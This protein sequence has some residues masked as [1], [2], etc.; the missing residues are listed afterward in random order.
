MVLICHIVGL[1]NLIKQDFITF[2]DELNNKCSG[3]IIVRDLDEISQSIHKPDIDKFIWKSE[4]ER[5]VNNIRKLYTN[6]KLIFIGLCTYYRDLR[7]RTTVCTNNKFFVNLD[8]KENAKQ[9]VK[10]NITKYLVQIINGN[11]PLQYLDHNFI[12]NQREKL[13]SLYVNMG[14]KLKTHE[15][16]K[17]WCEIMLSN[18]DTLNSDQNNDEP[19]IVGSTIKYNEYIYKKTINEALRNDL[20]DILQS[21]SNYTVG[22]KSKWMALFSVVGAKDKIMKGITFNDKGKVVYLKEIV[23]DGFSLLRRNC[24]IYYVDPADMDKDGYRYISR[25]KVKI[26]R[27]EYIYNILDELER[28]GVIFIYF[29]PIKS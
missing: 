13:M 23:S 20:R 18:Y 11:F 14:Y 25:N 9:I 21:R 4:F 10:Y 2:I 28:E 15:S 26:I 12:K 29:E 6:K 27:R 8:S 3:D 5:K 19:I 1:N 7:I 24:Y 16:I 22:F 17:K